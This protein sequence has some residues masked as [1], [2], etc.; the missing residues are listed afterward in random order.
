MAALWGWVGWRVDWPCETALASAVDRRTACH[1]HSHSAGLRLWCRARLELETR[2]AF[3]KIGVLATGDTAVRAAHSLAADMVTEQ[4]VVVGPA[5]SKNFRVVPDA[6]ECDFLIATGEDA[7][8]RARSLGKPLIWDGETQ[9][10]GVIVYGASPQGLALSLAAR[11]PDPRVVAVAHPELEGGRDH[12][13][14][15][16][17]PVGKLPVADSIY[18]GRRLATGHS[19][20]RFAACLA[21]GKERRVTI[22]DDGAFLSGIALAA[23]V[24][25]LGDTPSSV[26]QEALAYLQTATDMGLVMG[27]A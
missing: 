10:D 21:V 5:R 24:A 15:F 1:R 14:R 20:D 9:A 8:K 13:V 12:Q 22:I 26:W 16:P 18:G 6:D 23:G 27:A 17:D 7:P 2:R 19:T 11:E 25:A 4:V 3:V